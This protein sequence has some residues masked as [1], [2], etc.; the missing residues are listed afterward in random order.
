MPEQ[1]TTTE[2][3]T[4]PVETPAPTQQTTPPAEIASKGKSPAELEAELERTR[5]A[6]KEANKEAASR[7]KRQEELEAAEAERTKAAMSD[8]ERQLA[9]IKELEDLSAQQAHLLKEKELHEL[10]REVAAEIGIPAG[11]AKK[12]VGATREEM[13]E[14]ATAMLELLPKQET[15]KQPAPKLEVT[16]PGGGDK[17]E[18]RNS[19]PWDGTGAKD[20]GGGVVV[21]D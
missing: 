7:R 16:N 13:I 12:I 11:L 9:R 19:N 15:A 21:V 20:R 6:L 14:D 18:T 1:E 3:V 5:A 10:R 4:P 8:T 17:G 2:M